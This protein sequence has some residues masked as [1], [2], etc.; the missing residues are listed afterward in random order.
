MTVRWYACFGSCRNADVAYVL[1]SGRTSIH[2]TDIMWEFAVALLRIR[3]TEVFI[4]VIHFVV[5]P[6]RSHQSHLKRS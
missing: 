4:S 2:V 5:L 3:A 1:L 6:G